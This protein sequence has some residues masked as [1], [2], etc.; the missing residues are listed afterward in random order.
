MGGLPRRGTHPSPSLYPHFFS[1]KPKG[2]CFFLVFKFFGM[3]D[4]AP[5]RIELTPTAV[6]VWSLNHWTARKSL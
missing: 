4:L 6:E 5:P 2:K 3:W 1:Q